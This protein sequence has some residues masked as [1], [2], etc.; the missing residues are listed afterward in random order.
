M[1]TPWRPT[2]AC[3]TCSRSGAAPADLH[4]PVHT[5]VTHPRLDGLPTSRAIFDEIA[6]G[7]IL[8]H[9]PYHSFDTS[10]LRFL[11][12]GRR[13]I[14]PS[15]R[16]SSRST[17][18]APTLRSSRRWP[19]R[20]AAAS[21]WPCSWR[22]RHGSTRR[23]TSPGGSTSRTRGCHVAYGVEQLKTHVKLAL[24]VREEKGRRPPL[25]PHRQRELPHRDGAHLRGRRAAHVPIRR[26]ARTWRRSSTS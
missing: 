1:S 7:D 4:Y 6:R 20:R 23:P 3:A 25:R 22:S 16:S 8:L 12:V 19:R 2:S 10:V 21:R 13:T 18:P 11:E 9:H 17:A 15:S 26:F 24:V 14:L 5:P